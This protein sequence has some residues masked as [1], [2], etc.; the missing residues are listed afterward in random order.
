LRT[1][2]NNNFKFTIKFLMTL[3]RSYI[4]YL[5]FL[6]IDLF[7]SVLMYSNGAICLIKLLFKMG[8][9]TVWKGGSNNHCLA[10]VYTVSVYKC[11][12]RPRKKEGKK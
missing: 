7:K 9:F 3:D 4:G 5:G 1:D 11:S 2:K 6:G 12:F 10:D 8:L